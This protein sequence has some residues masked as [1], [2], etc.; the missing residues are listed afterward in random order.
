MKFRGTNRVIKETSGIKGQ[1]Q[2]L[3]QISVSILR[4]LNLLLAAVEREAGVPGLHMDFSRKSCSL[5]LNVVFLMSGVRGMIERKDYRAVDTLF[6]ILEAYTDRASQFQNGADMTRV[7]RMYSV[8]VFNV[9]GVHK[10]LE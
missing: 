4:G 2:P 10:V 8:V 6:T 3:S 7:Y 5:Q 9:Q 1:R